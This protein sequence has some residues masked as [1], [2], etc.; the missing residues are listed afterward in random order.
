MIDKISNFSANSA[1]NKQ[2]KRLDLRVIKKKRVIWTIN[3]LKKSIY[4]LI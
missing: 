1:I 4:H 2:D 3:F